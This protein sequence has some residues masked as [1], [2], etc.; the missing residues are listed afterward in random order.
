MEDVSTPSVRLDVKDAAA[1]KDNTV[2]EMTELTV[3]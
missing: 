3:A 2:P 1:E